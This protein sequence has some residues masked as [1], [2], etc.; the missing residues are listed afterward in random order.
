MRLLAALIKLLTWEARIF[1]LAVGVP[2]LAIAM[3]GWITCYSPDRWLYVGLILQLMG[4]ALVAYGIAKTRKEFRLGSLA[5]GLLNWFKGLA[6]TIFAAR[7]AVTGTGG[8]DVSAVLSNSVRAT[9]TLGFAPGATIEERLVALEAAG[10]E[11]HQRVAEV[12]QDLVEASRALSQALANETTSR[13]TE[14]AELRG[15]LKDLAVGG[16]HLE[17]VGVIWL[18]LATFASTI[19]DKL[20]ALGPLWLCR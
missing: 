14:L 15:A 20:P 1:W 2:V 7:R 12:R 3:T 6:D 4:L 10:R 9:G 5:R 8:I 19:P 16:I 17:T 13:S 18:L 11:L